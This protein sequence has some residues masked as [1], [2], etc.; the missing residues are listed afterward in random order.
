MLKKTKN[1]KYTQEPRLGAHVSAAGSVAEAVQRAYE[2]GCE[3]FQFFSRSPRGGPTPKLDKHAIELFRQRSQGYGLPSVIHA[4]YYINFA[5]EKI[6]IRK[7]SSRVL[8]EELERGS[9]LGCLAMMTHLGSAKDKGEKEAIKLTVEGIIELLKGYQGSTQ[10]LIEISAGAGAIIGDSFEEIATIIKQ[11][12]KKV[13]A[14]VGICFDTCHAFVSGYDLR[15][16]KEVNKTLT[17]FNKLIGHDRLKVIHL[18]DAK[19]K[20]GSHRDRHEHI[21][22]GEIG[23]EGFRALLRHKKMVGSLAILETPNDD[24][25]SEDLKMI[26][27]LRDNQE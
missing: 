1:Y 2:L 22:L 10:F 24:R 16:A 18:N 20:L 14:K 5:S 9:Q 26:K 7:A 17:E 23:E 27:K 12:E 8:R 19:F 4:P 6:K 15:T 3:C 13:P 21:G 25:R 11:V